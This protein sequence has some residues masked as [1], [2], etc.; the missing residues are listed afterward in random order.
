MKLYRSC[1]AGW[2]YLLVLCIL[3]SAMGSLTGCNEPPGEP[4]PAT[5]AAPETPD[6]PVLSLRVT[7]APYGALGDGKTNDRA[8]SR[9]PLMRR[10]RRGAVW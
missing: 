3:F 9:P 4:S 2:V 1:H 7:D 10:K 6:Q 5:T 8:P